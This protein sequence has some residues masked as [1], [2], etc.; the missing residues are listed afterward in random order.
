MPDKIDEG[1]I[2][3]PVASGVLS[4]ADE[5][6]YI[7]S[8]WQLIWRKFRH[9]KLARVGG[10]AIGILAILAIFAEFWSP[11]DISVRHAEY[12]YTPPQRVRVWHDGGL[13]RPFVYG[14]ISERNSR[15]HAL[16]FTDDTSKV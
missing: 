4:Q 15:T 9:H 12:L 13:H 2:T 7:A 10:V 5:R 6:Y 14:L 16:E 8:Q 11:Y 3:A 1:Q